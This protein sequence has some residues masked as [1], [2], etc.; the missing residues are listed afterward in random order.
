MIIL[1]SIIGFHLVP[2]SLV[3]LYQ[4]L[5]KGPPI[6]VNIFLFISLSSKIS[7]MFVLPSITFVPLNLSNL[8]SIFLLTNDILNRPESINQFSWDL[9][10]NTIVQSNI[11]QKKNNQ[12][13]FKGHFQLHW[14]W[15]LVNDFMET[16]SKY[17]FD[18]IRHY[19]E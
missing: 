12:G 3:K 2:L 5:L 6:D 19:F 14:S 7:F 18:S 17:I 9:C 10:Q 8:I 16:C 13:N 4:H 11:L 1:K 15:P